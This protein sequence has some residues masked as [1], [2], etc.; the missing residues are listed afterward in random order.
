MNKQNRSKEMLFETEYI[1][2][3]RDSLSGRRL[4]PNGKRISKGTVANYRFT[5]SL[6]QRFSNEKQFY[7]RLKT[8]KWL[9]SREQRAEHNYWKNFYRRFTNWLYDECGCFDNYV[10]QNLKNIR[11]FFNY[12]NKER[13]IPVGG[14]YKL[15]YVPKEE[16]AIFPLHPEELNFLIYDK[17]F[18][19]SLKPR[20]KEVKDFFVFGCTVALRF[21]DLS[22]LRK[23]NIRLVGNQYYLAVKSIKTSTDSLIKLPG[24]AVE[25]IHKYKKHKKQLLPHFNLTNINKYIKRLLEEAGF[26]QPILITR[27]RRGIPV[28]VKGD[29]NRFCDVGSTHTMRRTAITTMLSLG[30]PEQVVRKISGH[31]PNSKEFYRYVSWSQ[32]YQDQE[33]EKVFEKL[34]SKKLLPA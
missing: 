10:G 22:R 12:M 30:M 28:P 33:T 27:N 31:A 21:S 24:Y 20:M 14:F 25:I 5:L 3:I 6:L 17:D 13:T 18:E 1:R 7:L 26:V 15:F 19:N 9:N 23:K 11:S 8:S 29:K 16:I 4:Q 34:E 2:F 32:G